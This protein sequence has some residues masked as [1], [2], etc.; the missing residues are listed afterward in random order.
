MYR[1]IIESAYALSTYYVSGSVLRAWTKAQPL[2]KKLFELD[3]CWKRGNQF[4]LGISTT[5]RAGPVPR[6]KLVNT[7]GSMLLLMFFFVSILFPFGYFFVFLFCFK[8]DFI[9]NV[10]RERERDRDRERYI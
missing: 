7:M 5:L 8:F 2:T 1:K 6:S 9:F 3:T 4:S 10:V